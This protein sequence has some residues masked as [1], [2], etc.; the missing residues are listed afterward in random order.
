M[1][2]ELA[3]E[4][5]ELDQS[6]LLWWPD[7]RLAAV[8]DLHLE[9]GSAFARR[10][11]LLPPYDT[12]ETLAR[13][14]AALERLGPPRTV[15]SLGDG[16]HDRRG[17]AH[18]DPDL[19]DRV[20]RLTGSSEWL[21]VR[22]NHDP[23]PPA[24][25]GGDSAA[26]LRLG[27]LTFRHEPAGGPGEVA[28]HLHPKARVAASRLRLCRP[29]HASD[30]LRLLLPAFGSFTGGLNVLDPAIAGL[31]PGGFAA[32][33]LG[34]ARVFR[35]PHRQLEPDPPRVALAAARR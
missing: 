19:A 35:V 2:L 20:R 21:W 1:R 33:L 4:R 27:G 14:E 23:E 22:G 30:G 29:C 26:E 17:P 9:K 18:L 8:A 25:L 16:F 31:F 10:G 15:V 28:G 7:R 13:L 6:G 24:G 12:H 32:Y 11:R 3:G 5:L 34:E